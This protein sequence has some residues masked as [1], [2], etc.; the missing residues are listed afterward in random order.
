MIETK[1]DHEIRQGE[2]YLNVS[3]KTQGWAFK[4]WGTYENNIL[5]TGEK[6]GNDSKC[7][8]ILLK[9]NNYYGVSKL[10]LRSDDWT[11]DG[12]GWIDQSNG[13]FVYD[14]QVTIKIR[15]L[16]EAKGL[17]KDNMLMKGHVFG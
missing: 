7:W 8:S 16:F 10:N 4:E 13:K 3:N 14:G 17:F 9:I 2:S 11:I 1:L 5:K 6:K 12:E 15:D